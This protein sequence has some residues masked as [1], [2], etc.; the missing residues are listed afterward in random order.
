M[1]YSPRSSVIAVREKPVSVFVTVT[2]APGTTPPEASV[3]VPLISPEEALDCG[4]ACRQQ[5]RT[6]TN[7]SKIVF[8]IFLLLGGEGVCIRLQAGP[9]V[10]SFSLK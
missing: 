6:A 7:A 1:R 5:N 10:S 3:M 8:H 9:L 2:V 4:S